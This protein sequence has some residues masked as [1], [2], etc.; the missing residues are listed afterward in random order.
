MVKRRQ[1]VTVYLSDEIRERLDEAASLSGSNRSEFL[2]RIVEAWAR[3][4][5]PD[6]QKDILRRTIFVE[7]GVDALLKEHPNGELRSIVHNTH[8]N[9]LQRRQAQEEVR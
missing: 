8:K 4:Y 9:R 6:L 7:L 1:H 2:R 3:G 5:D